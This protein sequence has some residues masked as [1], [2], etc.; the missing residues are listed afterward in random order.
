[1][2]ESPLRS[3]TIKYG[4]EYQKT[5]ETCARHYQSVIIIIITT[6]ILLILPQRKQSFST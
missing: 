2:I 1:M 4:P 3:Q 5:I 6:I